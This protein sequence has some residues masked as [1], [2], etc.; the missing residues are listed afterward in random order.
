MGHRV[1]LLAGLVQT[2]A[3]VTES[4]ITYVKRVPQGLAAML[5]AV[6]LFPGWR[7]L[8]PI[9][10]IIALVVIFAILF[11]IAS[12]FLAILA[13]PAS[14]YAVQRAVETLV[15]HARG[16]SDPSRGTTLADIEASE[17]TRRIFCATDLS[18]GSH[19]YLTPGHVLTPSGAG[20]DPNVFIADVVAASA[21]FPG[22]RPVVFQRAELGLSIA[23]PPDQPRRRHAGGRLL[24]GFAGSIGLATAVAA[25][26]LRICGP[27]DSSLGGLGVAML[28]LL[29]GGALAMICARTL[30]IRDDLTLV[31]GGVCDNLGPAFALLSKD[32]RYPELPRLAGANVPGLMLVVDA[33]K[34]FALISAGWRGLGELIPLRVRGAQRSV[35]KLLGNANAMARKHVVAL[36]LSPEGS[37]VGAVISIGDVPESDGERDWPAVTEQAKRIP[38]TLDALK[39]DAVGCL[40]MQS[41]RLTQSLLSAH[42]VATL[43]ARSPQE[44]YALAESP[45]DKETMKLISK[46]KGP[47]ARQY[48]RVFWMSLSVIAILVVAVLFALTRVVFGRLS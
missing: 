4:V 23:S 9:Y 21:C 48:S 13:F 36:L 39:A 14:W 28:L 26:I 20:R 31:D 3:I 47:Y 43:K 44:I 45:A 15:W 35:L 8:N 41:Y 29:S 17:M 24:V 6:F 1:R 16:A 42:G 38:T 27:L 25:V 33:S 30:W 18:S 19:V 2:N 12:G 5:L 37:T 32:D 10:G 7:N 46:A 11:R 22:F 40:L 34:P